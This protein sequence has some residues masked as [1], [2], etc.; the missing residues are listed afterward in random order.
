MKHRLKDKS[1]IGRKDLLTILGWC[2][3]NL[4]KSK[5]YSIRK[6]RI[7]FDNRMETV[8]EFGTF[9]NCIYIN[10]TY[11]LGKK[12]LV[13]TIIHEYVHFLQDPE[14]YERFFR[15]IKIKNYYDHPHESEAEDIAVKL[16]N[17]CYKYY[18][19]RI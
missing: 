1:I 13:T 5:F 9:T 15:E 6:L 19:S 11:C 17:E 14:E 16:T 8:G 18:K 12:D 7:R 2:K 3:K 10:P 4:G